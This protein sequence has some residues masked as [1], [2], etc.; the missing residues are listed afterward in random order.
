MATKRKKAPGGSRPLPPEKKRG[1]PL[2]LKL[3][4]SERSVIDR[5]AELDHDKPVPWTRH[6]VI[7]VAEYRVQGNHLEAAYEALKQSREQ[8]RK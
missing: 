7:A 4:M 5:A 1:K 6:V 2:V 8:T 3:S